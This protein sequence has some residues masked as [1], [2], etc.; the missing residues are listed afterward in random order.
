MTWALEQRLVTAPTARHVLL[1]LA[2]YADKTGKGAFPSASSLSE[3]T[4][5]ALRTVRTAL[6]QLRDAGAITLGNQAIAA[7][8]IDRHDR[9]PVVYDLAM[10][11]GAAAA[12]GCERGAADDCTGCSSCTNGVQLTQERGAAAAPNPSLK[13]SIKPRAVRASTPRV[14]KF[15]P[16]TARPVNVSAPVWAAYC[17]MRKA[18]RAVLTET[19]CQL[20]GKKL[21]QHPQADLVVNQSIENG[22][23]GIFPEKVGYAAGQHNSQQGNR[24][25]VDSVKQA[26]AAR[27]V[28]AGAAGQP[29]AEDDRDVRPPLDG[30]FRRDS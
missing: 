4:G 1:C 28:A 3:D 13:P 8:Y 23:T 20:I 18:K 14:E 11:R 7:A 15:D 5:L 17:E 22:W 30:E 19:A 10:K 9:R 24:S 16:I 12:C 29:L 26:I 2:N 21:A 6:D 27:E 25:A